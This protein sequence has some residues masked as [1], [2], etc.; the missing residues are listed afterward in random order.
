MA[1]CGYALAKDYSQQWINKKNNANVMDVEDII[2]V[3]VYEAHMV[4]DVKRY[5][6]NSETTR[7]ICRNKEH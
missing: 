3:V 5:V 6:V 2:G 7:H 4:T 1:L